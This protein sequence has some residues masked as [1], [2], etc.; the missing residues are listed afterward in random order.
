LVVVLVEMVVLTGAVPLVPLVV[1]LVV[2]IVELV[3]FV[4]LV[5]VITTA[6]GGKV[7]TPPRTEQR[8]HEFCIITPPNL[9]LIQSTIESNW[10]DN[11]I[12]FSSIAT[13]SLTPA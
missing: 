12:E 11:T 2:V 7:T 1:L 3:E 5:G 4:P 8:A 9:E 10:V 13:V 6:G